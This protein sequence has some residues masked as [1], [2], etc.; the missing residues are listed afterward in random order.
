MQITNNL[1]TENRSYSLWN[2]MVVW[3]LS[4]F[5][6]SF[7]LKRFYRIGIGSE[8]IGNTRILREIFLKF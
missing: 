5:I 8:H 2:S 7:R 1:D 3:I 4:S 6:V